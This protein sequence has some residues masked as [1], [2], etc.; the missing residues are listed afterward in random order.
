MIIQSPSPQEHLS[1]PQTRAPFRRVKLLVGGYLTVSAATFVAIVLL[2][3]HA[4][5]V[6][7]A[8]WIRGTVVVA[9]ALAMLMFTVRAAGGSRRMYLRLRIVSAIM[10]VAIAVIAAMPGILPLW[11]RIEQ[12]VCGVILIAVVAIVN[13][14]RMRSLFAAR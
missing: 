10:V 4:A 12:G 9:S 5:V 3:N 14:Q 2:R 7:S 6:D 11:M 1:P 13:S 8:V